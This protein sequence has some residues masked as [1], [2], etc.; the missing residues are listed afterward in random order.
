MLFITWCFRPY[1]FYVIK[2]KKPNPEHPAN[3]LA[4]THTK[5]RQK[6]IE[7]SSNGLRLEHSIFHLV[8]FKSDIAQEALWDI[9]A[10]ISVLPS[11]PLLIQAILLQY[12]K[13]SVKVYCFRNRWDPS[14]PMPQNS[15]S[16]HCSTA[17]SVSAAAFWYISIG[18]RGNVSLI[19][20]QVTR[21][22]NTVLQHLSPWD[23]TQK[24]HDLLH[25]SVP[26]NFSSALCSV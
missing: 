2:K 26:R 5:A 7:P 21:H 6:Q 22:D 18:V 16:L 3:S 13:E 8:R 24:G 12:W 19:S 4:W 25:W 14:P 11:H 23:L 15:N 9:L 10:F 17:G 20:T 1:F